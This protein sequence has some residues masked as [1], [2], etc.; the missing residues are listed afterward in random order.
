MSTP[1]RRWL[2]RAKYLLETLALIVFALGLV[3]VALNP[4]VPVVDHLI[5]APVERVIA[6]YDPNHLQEYVWNHETNPLPKRMVRTSDG[7][8]F[9]SYFKGAFDGEVSIVHENGWWVLLGTGDGQDRTI[10]ARARCWRF[11]WA[12]RTP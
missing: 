4:L 10:E 1:M 9:L 12:D 8:C 5:A 11:P 2:D 6:A 3:G 7:I